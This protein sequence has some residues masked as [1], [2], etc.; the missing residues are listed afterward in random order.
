MSVLPCNRSGCGGIMCDRYHYEYGYI[1]DEC[2]D[3]LVNLGIQQEVADFM[4]SEKDYSRQQST[5]VDYE[6]FN[7]IF[8]DQ[9]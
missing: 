5:D 8:T 6:H 2:F 4:N 1:C 7:D 3:E 9:S